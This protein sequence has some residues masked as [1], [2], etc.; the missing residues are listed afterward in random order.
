MEDN[1]SNYDND[2]GKYMNPP[3]SFHYK[4]G[5]LV[6]D[7]RVR[8][9]NYLSHRMNAKDY[10]NGLLNM[11]ILANRWR[12]YGTYDRYTHYPCPKDDELKCTPL[13]GA[14]MLSEH[15][16]RKFKKDNNLH[17]VNAVF[18]TDGESSGSI[19]RYD[20][21]KE[22]ERDRRAGREGLYKEKTNIYIKDTKT[23]K[24]HLIMKNGFTRRGSGITPALLD[25][26]K[27]RL[28]IN[29]VGFFILN[30][31][32]NSQLWRYVPQKKH[33]TYEAGQVHYLNWIKKVKKAG[34]FIKEENGYDEYYVIKGD[35][36]KKA[37]SN[38]LNVSPEMTAHRM[39]QNF[40][41]KNNSFKTNRIILSRF[42]DLITENT[43]V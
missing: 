21:T 38:D 2:T 10:N 18:L 19:Y 11:C 23:K 25:I 15:V 28:G 17:N 16:I 27:G 40:M 36:L 14:I 7:C 30:T 4:N 43:T 29:I 5:D 1:D 20:A 26:V 8:L 34:F 13:N 24:N 42:I 12:R 33:V 39:A 9:R 32:T 37:F 31:F 3:V 35:A 22:T 41:K 6:V